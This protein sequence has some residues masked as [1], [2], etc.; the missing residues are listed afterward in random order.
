M[1]VRY[2]FAFSRTRDDELDDADAV[3]DWKKRARIGAEAEVHSDAAEAVGPD[4]DTTP[5]VAR[6]AQPACMSGRSI[7]IECEGAKEGERECRG[8]SEIENDKAKEKQRLCGCQQSGGQAC[9]FRLPSAGSVPE[10]W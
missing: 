4:T 3:A 5:R 8:E 6:R 7:L 1:L 9:F 2:C 10:T